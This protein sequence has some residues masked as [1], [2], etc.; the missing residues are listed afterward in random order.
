MPLIN[1]A[2]RVFAFKVVPSFLKKKENVYC[3][4]FSLS[5]WNRIVKRKSIL[6][7]WKKDESKAFS[8]NW[9]RVFDSM[10]EGMPLSC[11]M[12]IVIGLQV[13]YGG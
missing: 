6:N 2:S 5:Y 11:F 9:E 8:E 7:M 3:S 12:C 1:D 10:N 4:I 13:K